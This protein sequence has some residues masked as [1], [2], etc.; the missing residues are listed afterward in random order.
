V[1][2]I[3]GISGSSGA[4]YGVRLVQVLRDDP[5]IEVHLVM[6]DAARLTIAHE[7]E[8]TPDEVASWADVVHDVRDISATISSGSFITAGMAV[9]PCSIRTL[10]SIANSLN[11]NL[12]TRAADVCLKERRKLVIVPRETPLHLGHLRQMMEV[13][14]SGAVVLPPVPSFYHLPK[15]VMDIVDHTVGKVLDQFEIDKQLFKRWAGL[16]PGVP[17]P[18]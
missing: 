9:A 17:R 13:T 11:D 2:L 3:V 8:V 7:T 12:L 15:T 18:E 6:S 1:R 10:A 14:Q 4:I 16:P 5:N